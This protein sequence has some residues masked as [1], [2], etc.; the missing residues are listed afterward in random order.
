M[1]NQSIYV[2]VI[3]FIP[4]E[5]ILINKVLCHKIKPC[6]SFLKLFGLDSGFGFV[7]VSILYIS[8]VMY[9]R[10]NGFIRTY[11][12]FVLYPHFY[13]HLQKEHSKEDIYFS[14]FGQKPGE[15]RQIMYP[16]SRKLSIMASYFS[17]R[18]YYNIFKHLI[19]PLSL[20]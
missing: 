1:I 12:L 7:C 13:N 16:Q 19:S 18:K 5:S 10:M 4:C 8:V 11:Y 3:F 2:F 17:V 15:R 9:F 20:K 14:F 6:V